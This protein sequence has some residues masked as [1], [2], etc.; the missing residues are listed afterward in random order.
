MARA[1]LPRRRRPYRVLVASA[2]GGLALWLPP[3]LLPWPVAAVVQLAVCAGLLR[4]WRWCE[5]ADRCPP[6]VRLLVA[7]PVV[8]LLGEREPLVVKAR[9]LDRNQYRRRG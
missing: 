5:W 9:W 8:W 3:H 2:A 7:R 4:A 6:L 1:P